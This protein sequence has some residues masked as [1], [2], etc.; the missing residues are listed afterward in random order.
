[1]EVGSH[2]PAKEGWGGYVGVRAA[3]EGGAIRES[4]LSE[5]ESGFNTA[6]SKGIRL[7]GPLSPTRQQKDE[8]SQGTCENNSSEEEEQQVPAREEHDGK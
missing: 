4:R 7:S 6:K 1:M 2:A 3:E 8:P 5:Q